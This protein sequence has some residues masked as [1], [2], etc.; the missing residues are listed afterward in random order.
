MKPSRAGEHPPSPIPAE[1]AASL[2][3]VARAAA[4]RAYVPYSHFPVGAAVLTADGTIVAGCNVENASYPLTVCAERVAVATAVAA[5]HQEIAAVAVSAPKAAG[6]TP[7]GGCRQVLNEFKPAH[8]DLIVYLDVEPDV[9][10]VPLGTLL[11]DSFG[12]RDLERAAAK[13]D[14]Q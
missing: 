3:D 14:G 9:R 12:P 4:A 10:E 2:M 8:A 13:P 1:T 6:T 5:G 7:C 11:P